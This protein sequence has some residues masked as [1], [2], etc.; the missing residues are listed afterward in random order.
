MCYKNT[1]FQPG[2]GRLCAVN[3]RRKCVC[4]WA[5]AAHLTMPWE[6]KEVS[7]DQGRTWAA[8]WQL[9]RQQPLTWHKVAKSL[10]VLGLNQPQAQE[11]RTSSL[12][13]LPW[14]SRRV[15]AG[16][17]VAFNVHTWWQSC[18]WAE[19]QGDKRAGKGMVL[20]TSWCVEVLLCFALSCG[21]VA[22]KSMEGFAHVP[23]HNC[24]ALVKT[25]LSLSHHSL[26]PPAASLLL[27]TVSWAGC[28]SEG[29]KSNHFQVWHQGGISWCC[30]AERCAWT[31]W[32]LGE[33]NPLTT[34]GNSSHWHVSD[35]IC[36][37]GDFWIRQ[38]LEV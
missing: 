19:S 33:K 12:H 6:E 9:C 37:S 17:V 8:L 22:L 7:L 18:P 23:G 21:W 29:T 1:L 4:W 34:R 15:K 14:W 27:A 26:P 10:V 5:A 32:S 28:N 31:S 24:L 35:S 30:R 20:F 2:R 16:W 25:G 13:Y 3:S 36:Y 38:V 11:G